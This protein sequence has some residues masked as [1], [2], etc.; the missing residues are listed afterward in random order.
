MN[1]EFHAA[2]RRDVPQMIEDFRSIMAD[3]IEAWLDAHVE[4]KAKQ[5]ESGVSEFPKGFYHEG[6]SY[7]FRYRA[8]YYKDGKYV[9]MDPDEFDIVVTQ[10][11]H[12][13]YTPTYDGLR[14]ERGECK[15]PFSRTRTHRRNQCH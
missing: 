13:G 9:S 15:F 7:S 3:G 5:D 6:P 11:F 4:P 2:I 8:G 12:G 10:T 1:W 14:I